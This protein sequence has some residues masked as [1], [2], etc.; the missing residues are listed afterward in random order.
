[1]EMATKE[2]FQLQAE[3]TEKKNLITNH[4]DNIK[5]KTALQPILVIRTYCD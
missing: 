4:I 5:A 1:M 2:R 3:L